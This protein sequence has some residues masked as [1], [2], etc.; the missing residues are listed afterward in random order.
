MPLDVVQDFVSKVK[1]KYPIVI[2]NSILQPH[3]MW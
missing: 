2:N 3:E 1:K